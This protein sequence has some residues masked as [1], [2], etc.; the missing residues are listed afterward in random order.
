[1]KAIEYCYIFNHSDNF[2]TIHGVGGGGVQ[3]LADI[4]FLPVILFYSLEVIDMPG[5]SGRL[6][7]VKDR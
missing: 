4:P 1:M 2:F 6:T 5:G 7:V 3:P